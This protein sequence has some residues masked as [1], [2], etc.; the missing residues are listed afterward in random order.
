LTKKWLLR[1]EILYGRLSGLGM[2]ILKI[3]YNSLDRHL[4]FEPIPFFAG[5]KNC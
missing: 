3:I 4:L 2:R 1:P 5:P